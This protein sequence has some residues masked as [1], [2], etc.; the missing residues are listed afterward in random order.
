MPDGFKMLIRVNN[1][2]P[3]VDLTPDMIDMIKQTMAKRYNVATK[4]LDLTKFHTDP[5]LQ[6]LFCAL[7]KPQI[8]QVVIDIIAENIPEIEALNLFD[9]KIYILSHLRKVA[10]KMPN[11]KILHMGNN[12]VSAADYAKSWVMR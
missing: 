11:L 12:R 9:N 5:D 4:A 7:F 6:H 3:I 10:Q 2:C 8:L 1:G